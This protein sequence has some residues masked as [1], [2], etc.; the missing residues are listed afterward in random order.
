MS[1]SEKSAINWVLLPFCAD[2]NCKIRDTMFKLGRENGALQSLT[3]MISA[4]PQEV[5]IVKT[6]YWVDFLVADAAITISIE[7]FSDIFQSFPVL[8]NEHDAFQLIDTNISTTLMNRFKS[9]SESLK[10]A[11]TPA[12]QEQV[13]IYLRRLK[14]RAALEVI[15]F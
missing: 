15:S 8:V 3:N 5:E 9:L 14:T 1:A 4:Q 11:L 12:F 7:S 13:I 6:N 2:K 10:P